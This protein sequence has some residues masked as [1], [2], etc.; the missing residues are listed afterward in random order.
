[1]AF[2]LPSLAYY[3]PVRVPTSLVLAHEGH[4]VLTPLATVLN[5]GRFVPVTLVLWPA[6]L[7]HDIVCPRGTP[8]GSTILYHSKA[9]RKPPSLHRPC[10]S[11]QED[12]ARPFCW[13]GRL[14]TRLLV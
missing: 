14:D 13:I 9:T 1:M 10:Y 5:D 3:T 7:T 2:A 12:Q 6:F 8:F 4:R 11:G